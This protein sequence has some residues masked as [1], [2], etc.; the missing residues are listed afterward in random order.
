MALLLEICVLLA[1]LDSKQLIPQRHWLSCWYRRLVATLACL[2]VISEQTMEI[3]SGDYSTTFENEKNTPSGQL[4]CHFLLRVQEAGDGDTNPQKPAAWRPRWMLY[5][6]G[7]MWE[8]CWWWWGGS[9]TSMDTS[10]FWLQWWQAVWAAAQG[11][12]QRYSRSR[13]NM[14]AHGASEKCLHSNNKPPQKCFVSVSSP[15]LSMTRTW[16]W[17]HFHCSFHLCRVHI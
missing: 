12:W 5:H 2:S 17:V 9:I 13:A 4:V 6:H 14:P 1:L 11:I 7:N 3:L 8:S 16:Q 10:S 15:S